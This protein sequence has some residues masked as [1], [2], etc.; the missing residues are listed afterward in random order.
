MQEVFKDGSVGEI[1]TANSLEDLLPEIKKALA[2]NEVDYVKIFYVN[3]GKHFKSEERINLF[4]AITADYTKSV[5]IDPG[6]TDEGQG[7]NVY[8]RGY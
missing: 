7:I 6:D 5:S 3:G 8:Y 1:K 4:K 2:K